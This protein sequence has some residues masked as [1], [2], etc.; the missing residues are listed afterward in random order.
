MSQT[1]LKITANYQ[2]TVLERILQVTRY[3]GFFLS[4]IN[5]AQINA[6]EIELYL[7]VKSPNPVQNLTRQLLK[8]VDVESIE[9]QDAN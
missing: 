7:Q 1:R 4:E 9:I 6:R 8:L 5:M 2:P 3:R